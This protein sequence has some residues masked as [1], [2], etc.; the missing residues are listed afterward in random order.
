MT[1][2]IVSS[3][4]QSR[5]CICQFTWMRLI[6]LPV[7]E[8]ERKHRQASTSCYIG[9]EVLNL[10]MSFVEEKNN[11]SRRRNRFPCPLTVYP[12]NMGRNHSGFH[13]K[14]TVCL[15]FCALILYGIVSLSYHRD[16]PIGQSVATGGS[17]H[18]H[19]LSLDIQAGRSFRIHLN[20]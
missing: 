1:V 13:S 17:S 11:T 19:V 10:P 5:Q 15:Y 20:P 2:L 6:F 14:H 4:C 8:G 16:S 12:E 18:G 7:G 9:W 3:K